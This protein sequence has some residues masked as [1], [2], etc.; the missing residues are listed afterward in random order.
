MKLLVTGSASFDNK[1]YL[2]SFL[3]KNVGKITKLISRRGCGADTIAFD[4][5]GENG[6]D[7][8]LFNIKKHRPEKGDLFRKNFKMIDCAD[9]VLVFW[10]GVSEGTH[11]FIKILR[12]KKKRGTILVFDS[13]TQEITTRWAIK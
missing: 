4:W 2:N 3:N 11:K 12:E 1:E 5:A 10:D 6:V 7:C 8:Y 13:E 9:H